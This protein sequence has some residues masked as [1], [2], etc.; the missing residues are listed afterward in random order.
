MPRF[1]TIMWYVSDTQHASCDY[2]LM[3]SSSGSVMHRAR[4]EIHKLVARILFDNWLR[5]WPGACAYVAVVGWSHLLVNVIL[6]DR[7]NV[8]CEVRMQADYELPYSLAQTDLRV[9]AETI[10]RN[11]E[12][13]V[14]NLSKSI[15]NTSELIR[16][17]TK[18]RRQKNI[19]SRRRMGM[20][21][22]ICFLLFVWTAPSSTLALAYA[23]RR[24]NREEDCV[25][26]TEQ[27]LL[28]RYNDTSLEMLA[29]L[30]CGEYDGP[31]SVLRAARRF[32][33]EFDMF[34]FVQEQNEKKGLAPTME[35]V[36]A[37]AETADADIVEDAACDEKSRLRSTTVTNR[38][39]KWTKRMQRFRQRWMLRRGTFQPGERLTE[40][41]TRAKV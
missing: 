40:E 23:D 38:S 33:S 22:E 35:T 41:T 4:V 16:R 14:G 31:E 9:F 19:A 8:A 37:H 39:E 27:S 12:S 25:E 11:A 15:R 32:K 29:K 26:I 3:I 10:M 13:K 24:Q 34:C 6:G 17:L 7:Q 18:E 2:A 1:S 28:E 21:A 30:M 20:T 5:H 36:R